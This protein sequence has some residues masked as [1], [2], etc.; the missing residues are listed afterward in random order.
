L[1]WAIAVDAALTD[2]VLVSHS[3][4]GHIAMDQS[5]CITDLVTQYLISAVLPPVGTA[6]P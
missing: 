5:A 2:S 3:A 6:C 4:G 1:D